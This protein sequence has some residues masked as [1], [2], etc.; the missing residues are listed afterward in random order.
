MNVPVLI[1]IFNRP[2]KFRVLLEALRNVRP[3]KLFISADGPRHNHPYDMA[4]C[5]QARNVVTEIDWPCEVVTR[6]LNDNMGCDPHVASAIGWF[7]ESVEYGIIFEDDVVPHPDFFRFCAEL[8]ERYRDDERMM[9]IS[10]ISPYDH[11]NHPYSYHFSRYFR[12]HGAWG[13]WKRAWHYHSIPKEHYHTA[14]LS[15]IIRSYFPK[16]VDRKYWKKLFIEFM[17][18]SRVNWDYWWNF[19][20]YAQNG[21]CIVPESNFVK[22]IGF[23]ESATHTKHKE[24]VFCDLKNESMAFPLAHPIFVFADERP[25]I[26]FRKNYFGRL[27]LKS[28]LSKHVKT[29]FWSLRDYFEKIIHNE[30]Y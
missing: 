7:F 2:D 15:E 30:L 17:S 11:R 27:T 24:P 20:C 13:T 23:D 5:V 3:A 21:L 9:Q 18:G 29:L 16:P 12:C 28:R 10:S 6:F 1:T 25:E 19:A 26:N 14:D 22:N 8:F 4:Q